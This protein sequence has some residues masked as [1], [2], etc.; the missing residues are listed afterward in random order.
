MGDLANEW[1]EAVAQGLQHLRTYKLALQQFQ[2]QQIPENQKLKQLLEEKCPQSQTRRSYKELPVDELNE[3]YLGFFSAFEKAAYFVEE[4]R[5]KFDV[6]LNA[7]Y[8]SRDDL[9]QILD[10]QCYLD[11]LEQQLKALQSSLKLVRLDS[12][13]EELFFAEAIWETQPWTSQ[14]LLENV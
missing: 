3:S 10:K 6:K 5:S 12:T 8:E 13:E 11:K 14:P 7:H 1:D 9:N 2:Q 4:I